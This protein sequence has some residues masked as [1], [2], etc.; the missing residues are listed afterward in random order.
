LRGGRGRAARPVLFAEL[1][2]RVSP[3]VFPE[4]NS[5]GVEVVAVALPIFAVTLFVSA[6]I[7]FL[8]QPIVGAMILPKLGG[9]P[10]VWNTCMVF[11]QAVLLAGYAYAHFISTRFSVRR[12]LLI[13]GLVLFVPII[14][15]L[16]PLGPLNLRGD[17]WTPPLG[18]NPIGITLGI[19]TLVVGV[20]F[21]VVA[22]SAPLLQK[23]FAY[24][25]DKAA[26]DP[27]FLYAA[28]NAGSLLALLA[29]PMLLE[30]T[31]P[32]HGQAVTFA[33]GYGVLIVLVLVCAFRVWKM[34]PEVRL[35]PV[36]AP[37]PEVAAVGA[38]AETRESGTATAIAE[39]KKATAIK[40]GP[41]PPQRDPFK[42]A[43]LE[44]PA[45]AHGD[46]LTTWRR[47]RWV[48]L[49]AIPSSMMLGVTTHITIDLTPMPIFWLIPLTLYL[50][51][52]ILVFSRWPTVWTGKPHEF[53][54]YAQPI[55]V[56]LMIISN[57]MVSGAQDFFSVPVFLNV[58]AFFLTALVCHGELARDR[59]STK[60]LTEFYL[61]MSL[62]GVV[63]GS[64]NA[65][66]APLLF[67]ANWEYPLAII[68]ACLVRPTMRESG[69]ADDFVGGFL[70]TKTPQPSQPKKKG[71]KPAPTAAAKSADNASFH[72]VM[73]AV[74]AGAVLILGLLFAFPLWTIVANMFKASEASY[75]AAFGLPLAIACFFF[76]RPL[77]LGGTVLAVL[78]VYGLF[79][80][81]NRGASVIHSDRSY[82]GFIRV[83]REEEM[84]PNAE[85]KYVPRM[86]H[87]L[88]HGNIDHGMN[89]R[90]PEDP[91]L[92]GKPKEDYSRL[93]TTY[94]H[95]LGPVGRVMNKFNWGVSYAT[96]RENLNVYS[97]D[98]RMPASAV[99]LAVAQSNSCNL[100]LASLV[101]AWSEPPYATIGLGTGTMASYGR[102]F[103]HVHFYEID[104]H[105]RRL[106][107]PLAGEALYFGYLR[108]A[109]NRGCNV[110]VLMGDARLRMAMPYETYQEEKEK[111]GEGRG[112]GPNS[113]YHMMVVDAFSSDAIPRHLLTR[114][115]FMMYFEKLA[116]EGI[117]CVHTSNRY[118]NLVKV[119]ADVANSI[120]MD[121]PRQ[122]T[123]WLENT[124][125]NDKFTLGEKTTLGR[126]KGSNI[127]LSDESAEATH[128]SV[129]K[130][131][132][133]YWLDSADP[134]A[135]VYLNGIRLTLSQY[136]RP[137]D[138]IQIGKTEFRYQEQMKKTKLAC[139]R[140][141]DVAP[142]YANI[143]RRYANRENRLG[144]YTSEWV[145]VARDSSLLTD[146]ALREPDDYRTRMAA[147]NAE[148]QRKGFRATSDRYWT[149][150][151]IRGQYVWTDDYSNLLWVM[152]K[153]DDE[154]DRD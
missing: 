63:G 55:A 117:L 135:P 47:V 37:A 14:F 43:T 103:G 96:E 4:R 29:Y 86:F 18:G 143:P 1:D 142:G 148:R 50:L 128:A 33:L 71:Q 118:V 78:L 2:V 58:L 89:F 108:D 13:H 79:T 84:M 9:T 77:R 65:L 123:V 110:Q 85:D 62:G 5:L 91:K 22:T 36:E 12:Q 109:G 116:P 11:F 59:P 48:L 72:Y 81:S 15:F 130:V 122:K 21:F 154:S 54:L 95:K 102:P 51:S 76:G 105:I 68:G 125:S 32:L 137:G 115:A 64:F 80:Q 112:G 88:M 150:P 140:A 6:F 114:Q 45:A 132:Y 99:G 3:W 90:K 10:Q 66:L 39:A 35:A 131:G 120:E 145:M 61:L 27:Y 121:N 146:P 134:K 73:D 98:A 133:S 144:H 126:D 7:L 92:I 119:V 31:L 106:S 94:Y 17:W 149:T 93:P 74:L 40:K 153:F 16:P 24:T 104:D 42:D 152:R 60:H 69:W 138:L 20:P 70:E 26:K 107:L 57:I 28:S 87:S 139:L 8:V 53:M 127:V 67:K 30:W 34:A 56:A 25:G 52:F 129:N 97:A 124:A 147:E 19:L 100:P 111:R 151:V 41:R 136:L 101:G 23:W 75:F 49:G 82:Y 113:F 44:T 38:G 83:Q 46:E 141:H